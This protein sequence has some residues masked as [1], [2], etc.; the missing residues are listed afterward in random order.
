MPAGRVETVRAKF[1]ATLARQFTGVAIS[2][3]ATS[4]GPFDS[5]C[6]HQPAFFAIAILGVST[7]AKG[8]VAAIRLLTH[9]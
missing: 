3:G 4:G 2:R 5:N 1:K 8:A 6:A 9:I 7:G